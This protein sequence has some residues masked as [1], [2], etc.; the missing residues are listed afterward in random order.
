MSIH[1]TA[2]MGP[3]GAGK[4]LFALYGMVFEPQ[5]DYIRLLVKASH[6]VAKRTAFVTQSSTHIHRGFLGGYTE[7]FLC[8]RIGQ[9]RQLRAAFHHRRSRTRC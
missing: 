2:I 6:I 7:R 8:Q 3:S 9:H 5:R 1:M 4:S